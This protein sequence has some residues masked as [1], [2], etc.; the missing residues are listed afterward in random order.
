MSEHNDDPRERRTD[1]AS[2]APYSDPDAR[3]H[4]PII[5]R[6]APLPS[7]DLKP[8]PD[9]YLEMSIA[10]FLEGV[11]KLDGFESLLNQAVSK[12]NRDAD[13]RSQ[14]RTE[15]I[16]ANFALTNGQVQRCSE[17]IEGLSGDVRRAEDHIKR[18]DDAEQALEKE[19]RRLAGE[20]SEL[21]G[22]MLKIETE[23]TELRAKTHA[24]PAPQIAAEPGSASP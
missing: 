9:S 11:Q 6:A 8:N 12:I 14:Q 2:R 22:K 24:P 4:D 16:N 23:L 15:E 10:K 18:V 19:I 1:P 7:P 17:L 3:L 13:A 5:P 20:L 21:R